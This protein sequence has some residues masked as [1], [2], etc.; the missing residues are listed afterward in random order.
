[1]FV[2]I[3]VFTKCR[4]LYKN[5]TLPHTHDNFA[6]LSTHMTAGLRQH[7]LLKYPLLLA[8]IGLQI[9]LENMK[10]NGTLAVVSSGS[11]FYS[12]HVPLGL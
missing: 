4:S 7:L 11:M 6:F 8:W 12:R 9:W 10:W 2:H 1:M 5:Y 3:G